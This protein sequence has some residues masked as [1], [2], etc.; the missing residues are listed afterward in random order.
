V[1]ECAQVVPDF[2]RS[3]VGNDSPIDL[4]PHIKRVV[5][6]LGVDALI[7]IGPIAPGWVTPRIWRKP[8][9]P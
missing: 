5:G 7:V 2:L 9:S 1:A 3:S 6:K 4:T 8:A